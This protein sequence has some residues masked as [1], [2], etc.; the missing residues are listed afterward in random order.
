MLPHR[1]HLNAHAHARARARSV[2]RCPRCRYDLSR[3]LDAGLTRCP[4]CG[5]PSFDAVPVAV[6]AESG[7][8]P[9]LI[10]AGF[11]SPLLAIAGAEAAFPLVSGAV[12]GVSGALVDLAAAVAASPACF[13]AAYHL[14]VR[15]GRS[16]APSFDASLI[17]FI[18]I[19]AN[20]LAVCLAW[21][22]WAALAGG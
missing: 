1:A 2:L 22:G 17:G 13:V 19:L 4:E 15:R 11:V 7:P 10:A 6:A 16:E 3:T 14:E 12:P 5:G 9:V 21:F 8:H 20:G 18:A